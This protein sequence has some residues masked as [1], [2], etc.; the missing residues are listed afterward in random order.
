MF[1]LLL[2]LSHYSMLKVVRSYVPLRSL[3]HCWPMLLYQMHVLHVSLW[4]RLTNI[5]KVM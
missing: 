1:L 2:D 3:H 4:D 5:R